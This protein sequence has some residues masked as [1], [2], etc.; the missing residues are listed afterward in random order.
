MWA[1][2]QSHL[3]FCLAQLCSASSPRHQAKSSAL[4]FRNPALFLTQALLLTLLWYPESFVIGR[5]H[6]MQNTS[7]LIEHFQAFLLPDTRVIEPRQANL[8]EEEWPKARHKVETEE[9]KVPFIK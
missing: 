5:H 4:L 1:L 6:L 2:V 8:W 3:E 7:K 9:Q